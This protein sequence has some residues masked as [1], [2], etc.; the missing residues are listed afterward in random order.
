[1]KARI[2][3]KGAGRKAIGEFSEVSSPLSI[4]MRPEMRTELESVARASGR[5]V[6]E[7]VLGESSSRSGKTVPEHEI[8]QCGHFAS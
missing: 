8:P 7:E 5:S 2:R 1:M 3:A 4:R 6:S